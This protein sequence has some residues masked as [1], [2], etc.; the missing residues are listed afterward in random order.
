MLDGESLVFLS[1]T[2]GD[3]DRVEPIAN[4]LLAAGVDVW[5]DTKRLKAG[6]QWD[7]EIRRALD[8]A[9]VIVV[10]ISNKSVNKRGYV[11]R[12]IR[13]ALEKAEEK[14]NDDI[15]LIPV[16]L[17][18]EVIV[19]EL[20]RHLQFIKHDDDRFQEKLIDAITHQLERV[21]S[22][23]QTAQ[24]NS[25]IHWQFHS[26]RES[27]DGL[28]GYESEFRLPGLTQRSTP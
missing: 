2:A 22:A 4:G 11:Q 5:L 18:E 6:Q 19:P 17:D 21:G 26:L 14:L 16:L 12:E 28:P 3:R 1:Y 25:D 24:N 8:K 23:I 9:D 27:R 10:F 15:Y 13:L 7:F 20:I